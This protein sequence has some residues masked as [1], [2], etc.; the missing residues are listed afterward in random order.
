MWISCVCVQQCSR[1]IHAVISTHAHTHALQTMCWCAQVLRSHG[2][3]SKD[4]KLTCVH[5]VFRS[6]YVELYIC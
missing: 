4:M 1:D 3:Y 6:A 5:V 2:K